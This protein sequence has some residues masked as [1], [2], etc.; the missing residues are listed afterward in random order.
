M[1]AHP[2]RALDAPVTLGVAAQLDL[3]GPLR[4]HQFPGIAVTKPFVGLLNLP[5]IGDHLIEDAELIADA[6]SQGGQ[7]KRRHRIEKTRCQPAQTAIAQTRLFLFGQQ[8]IEIQAE[9]GHRLLHFV[10][11]PE[12]DQVIA[13]MRPHQE[14]GRQVGDRACALP[15]VGRG[16]ADPALQQAVAHHKGERQITVGAACKRRKLALNIKKIVKKS[17]FERVL[18]QACAAFFALGFRGRRALGAHNLGRFHGNT[19]FEG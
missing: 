10:E 17:A 14:F 18:A 12:V 6:I 4:A 16:S 15:G 5:A 8:F 11:D 19:S 7:L 9:F 1:P 2:L 3:H 13:K